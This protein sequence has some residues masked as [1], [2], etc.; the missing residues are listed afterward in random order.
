MA[1]EEL[2]IRQKIRIQNKIVTFQ[3]VVRGVLVRSIIIPTILDEN[4]AGMVILR[5]L[6]VAVSRSRFE[7]VVRAKKIK[8]LAHSESLHRADLIKKAKRE[9]SYSSIDGADK[10]RSC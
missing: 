4:R 5:T 3:A 2:R 1:K 8:A 7:R 6:R 9:K 10:G